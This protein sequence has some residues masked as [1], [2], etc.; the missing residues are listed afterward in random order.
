MV[1]NWLD[2]N[3]QERDLDVL[4]EDKLNKSQQYDEVAKHVILHRENIEPRSWEVTIPFHTV[5]VK[6]CLEYCN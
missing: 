4:V 3:T 5:L 1:D 6:S 2:N